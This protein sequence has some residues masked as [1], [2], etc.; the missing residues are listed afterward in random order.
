MFDAH[1]RF[2]LLTIKL[3]GLRHLHKCFELLY[4]S[5]LQIFRNWEHFVCISS[6]Q[7]IIEVR[8]NLSIAFNLHIWMFTKD[9]IRLKLKFVC[10]LFYSLKW[11]KLLNYY[12]DSWPDNYTECNIL[13]FCFDY[14]VG[15][16][17]LDLVYS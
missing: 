2:P 9:M 15:F 8:I 5:C 11:L 14:W 3:I 13:Y 4:F 1:D 16:W 10:L 17:N 6:R 12:M 7:A